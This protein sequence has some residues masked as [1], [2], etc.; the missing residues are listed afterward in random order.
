MD[1]HT[2]GSSGGAAGWTVTDCDLCG[3]SVI[4]T[5]KPRDLLAILWPKRFSCRAMQRKRAQQRLIDNE[6]AR[7]PRSAP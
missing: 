2:W 5:T 4:G 6:I 3:L 7:A 1:A